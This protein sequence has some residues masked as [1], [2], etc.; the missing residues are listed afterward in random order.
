MMKF[1]ADI[2]HHFI[3]CTKLTD[4]SCQSNRP[5]FAWILREAIKDHYGPLTV[6]VLLFAN[7][8]QIFLLRTNL[9]PMYCVIY[10]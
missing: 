5:Y 3:I 2:K 8:M 4:L 10:Y 7:M 9:Y 1:C 6:M